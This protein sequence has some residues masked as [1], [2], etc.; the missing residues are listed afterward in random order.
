MPTPRRATTTRRHRSFNPPTARQRWSL[1]R[2]TAHIPCYS[3]W[4][5]HGFFVEKIVLTHGHIDHIRDA[6]EFGVPVYVHPLD[7]PFV[8]M[9]QSISPLAQLFDVNNMKPVAD[10][11][12]LGG[13]SVT[14]AGVDFTVHHMPGHSPG[15]VMFRVP[16]FIIGGDV[17]FRGGVGRTDLP[18]SSAED[19]VLSLKKLS[20]EFDDD[21]VVV[22]GHT[23]HY[24][25]GG[26]AHQRVLTSSTLSATCTS[27]RR[28]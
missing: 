10:V 24:R 28:C 15:H 8:E 16:G 20:H 3:N 22:T 26:K 7:R 9:D 11:R 1:I 18:G 5:H 12:D 17:L 14:L 25:W 6:G 23:S 27:H 13:D 21:D 4:L 2:V 19:M